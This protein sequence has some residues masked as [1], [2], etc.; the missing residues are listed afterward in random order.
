[1]TTDQTPTV[2][3]TLER[4]ERLLSVCDHYGW[5]RDTAAAI[6]A[7]LPALRAAVKPTPQPAAPGVV[8]ALRQHHEWAI[9]YGDSYIN[10]L[11][12]INTEAALSP[13]QAE[14]PAGEQLV[15]TR[16]LASIANS[17]S[18]MIVELVD[19]GL[20][21]GTDWKIGL[22]SIIELRLARLIKPQQTA[23]APK[24]T[25]AAQ[26]IC[27]MLA[28]SPPPPGAADEGWRPISE[29]INAGL[30]NDGNLYL[31]TDGRLVLVGTI[32][33]NHWGDLF[34]PTSDL[35]S[36][37]ATH[38]RPLPAPPATSQE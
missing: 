30:V 36:I 1:M 37:E 34:F 2:A 28:A 31:L 23:V 18:S 33:F 35:E 12:Y 7:G 6:V 27:A 15:A 24:P 22:S 11:L 4:I 38:W 9:R 14:Q 32:S 16:P 8:E 10:S 29:A 5:H 21:F 3:E 13:T 20:V 17:L 19:G 25:D 26:D